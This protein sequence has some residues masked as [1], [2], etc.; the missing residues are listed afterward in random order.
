MASDCCNTNVIK[1]CCGRPIQPGIGKDV[2]LTSS[3]I[4]KIGIALVLAGQSMVFGLGIN[5]TPPERGSG[6]Y[7]FLHGA[8]IVSS[9]IVM[10]L[11]GRSLFEDAIRNLKKR[12]LSLEGLFFLSAVGALIGSLISTITGQSE[13]Y[14]EV[15]AIVLV[16]Y[17]L[18]KLL[19][20]RSRQKAI[21]ESNKTREAFDYAYIMDDQGQRERVLLEKLDCCSEVVVGPGDAISVDGIII[22]G[23]GFVQETA[24]TGELD[25]VVKKVGDYIF[26]GSYCVD[27]VFTIKPTGLKGARRL[28]ILLNTVEQARLAPSALQEQADRIIQW[29]LPLVIAVSVGTFL[30]WVGRI[31]WIDALFNS[32]AVLL[33]ACPC[34]LGLA[35]PIAVWSG[36]WKLSKLGLI[37]RSGEFLDTLGRANLMIFD[38]T[39][40][41]SEE[42]LTLVDFIVVPEMVERKEWLKE[43]ICTIEA[44]MDHPIARTLSKMSI[45][46]SNRFILM[47]SRII[48]GKGIEAQIRECDKEEIITMH[49]GERDL[50]PSGNDC[51]LE[52]LSN[53][54]SKRSIF[55]GL[56]G[57]IVA[58]A[59]LDEKM[60]SGLKEVFFELNELNVKG[61]IL[62]GDG[63][64]QYNSIEG[65]E[66]L[67]GLS[68]LDKE[69]FVKE[70]EDSGQ[71]T[72]FL[73]DGINDAAAMAISS[74]SIAMGGGAALTQSTASAILMGDTLEVLPKAIKLCRQIRRSVRGNIIY[75]ISYNCFGMI[76]AATGVLHPV[77]AALIMLISSIGVSIRAT[78][79]SKI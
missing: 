20:T 55:V 76:L 3:L 24:M 13:V 52:S 64:R 4:W 72:I 23:T 28:D 32:M 49:L 73:G 29:F 10:I 74:A 58:I 7:I 42:N 30:F 22:M 44:Q 27:A 26:A 41:L 63:S 43:A 17:T 6:A 56:N 15:V 14:Y 69:S 21:D 67:S 5:I 38:K 35:T 48:P 34:A 50:I 75:A 31:S 66:V 54:Q 18:G 2:D 19:S 68:P 71:R 77:V 16:I 78:R 37:S 46:P 33:V 61:K 79:A 45:N 12:R 11:L 53:Y 1:D 65:V 47:S 57:K 25:P 59:L 40:T 39:G 70:L 9:I 36:L 62:T 60:R 51:N 8:L